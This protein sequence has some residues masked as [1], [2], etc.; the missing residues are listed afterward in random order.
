MGAASRRDPGG[1]VPEPLGPG[2]AGGRAR[3]PAMAGRRPSPVEAHL[4]RFTVLA[5]VDALP[6]LDR[7][8]R[9]EG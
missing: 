4:R 5:V 9:P 3:V 1:P 6:A 8:H 2:V 7:P